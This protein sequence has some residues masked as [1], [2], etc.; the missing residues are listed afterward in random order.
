MNFA[1]IKSS[2][3]PFD[4]LFEGFYVSQ[5]TLLS[6]KRGTGTST[7][8]LRFLSHL[9]RIGEKVLLFT[10]QPPAHV[11][12]AAPGFGADLAPALESDQLSIVPYDEQLPLLPFPEAL[13]ELRTLIAERHYSFVVFDPVMPWL[14]APSDQLAARLDAFFSLLS[15][16][17]AT[18]ILILHNPVS[19]IAH[20]LFDEV[21]ER[22]AICLAVTR[23]HEG[24]HTLQVT[25]YMGEPPEKCPATIH[26]SSAEPDTPP[27]FAAHASLSATQLIKV[28]L[29][30]S[31][32]ASQA[33]SSAAASFFPSA[34]A[35]PKIQIRVP[36]SPS[37]T[38]PISIP[39][40]LH[41]E[42]NPFF[43]SPASAPARAPSR[44]PSSGSFQAPTPSPSRAPRTIHFSDAL[45]DADR[46]A[47]SPAPS[48]APSFSFRPSAPQP[49]PPPPPPRAPQPSAP[50]SVPQPPPRAPQPPPADA[51][52]DQ[53]HPI[54][55]SDIIQ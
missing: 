41:Q 28:M 43:P 47:P 11:T 24:S 4:E 14:A 37:A 18:A 46:P 48:H 27:S 12:L 49:P 1:K 38:G 45:P 40:H 51:Q 44:A 50:A 55:F 30:S 2:I 9:V 3:A 32:A 16:T 22:C 17:E 8:A 31:A 6:G 29:P 33:S 52:N 53:G 25:K 36:A 5:P 19:K 13:E 54:R 39:P 10:D 26:L 42:N 15:S 35:R 34:P 21:S 20:R 23:S 7:I